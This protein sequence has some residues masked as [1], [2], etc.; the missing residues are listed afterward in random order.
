MHKMIS[1][2]VCAL[3]LLFFSVV[4]AQTSGEYSDYI[5]IESLNNITVYN[6]FQQS[7][8]ETEKESLP[9]QIPARIIEENFLMSD[10]L[11]RGIKFSLAGQEYFCLSPTVEEL[12][13]LLNPTELRRFPRKK[14]IGDTLRFISNNVDIKPE[15]TADTIL[16]TNEQL[17]R[18]LF[19][20]KGR[21]FIHSLEN[22]GEA[23]WLS[24][25]K[26][27][28]GFDWEIHVK[29]L[30]TVGEEK[31]PSEIT[32]FVELKI[33][34]INLV[35]DG[36]VKFYSDKNRDD[37]PYLELKKFPERLEL[38]LHRAENFDLSETILR[39][40]ELLSAYIVRE[41]ISVQAEANMITI[42]DELPQ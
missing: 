14:F 26:Y 37:V 42:T 30:K 9:I 36:L 39:L 23:G 33:H 6:R 35:L 3:T 12:E 29:P 2:F 31:F 22:P 38:R 25:R 17:F 24:I 19:S 21:Y 8:S 1:F 20:D 41:G 11:T 18:I 13:E 16:G 32:Q 4:N 15:F 27:R 5:F 34:E 10:N 28:K 7:L 40:R